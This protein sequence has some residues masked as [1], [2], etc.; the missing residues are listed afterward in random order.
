MVYE[1][2][3]N[4]KIILSTLNLYE[5]I[6][7]RLKMKI[8]NENNYLYVEPLNTTNV[9]MILEDWLNKANRCIS[10]QQWVLLDGIFQ[11]STL[12]PLFIKLIYDI[13]IKWSSFYK[14]DDKFTNMKKIDDC[15]E[16]LFEQLEKENGEVF[17]SRTMFYMNIMK[18]GISE[19][20][21][22]D[23]MSLDD[24]LLQSIFEYHSPPI[25]RFPMALWAKLK[26]SIS[27]YMVEKEI[28]D[29]KV[30]FW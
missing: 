2:P 5:G 16:Y 24:N 7:D 3:S 13:I 9:K 18:N 25:R 20:E 6:L 17:F 27:E 26:H 10:I 11:V 4:I 22:E 30:L 15:I 19:S 14:P 28:D 1:F 12:H 29:S 8:N 23:I 21:L